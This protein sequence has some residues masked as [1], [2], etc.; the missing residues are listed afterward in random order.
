MNDIH[1]KFS[2]FIY[3]A[4]I[5]CELPTCSVSFQQSLGGNTEVFHRGSVEIG[6]LWAENFARTAQKEPANY[7]EQTKYSS[8]E[9]KINLISGKL[10]YF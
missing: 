8:C 2:C 3:G 5:F 7:T 1:T 10:H 9:E 4:G 6:Q